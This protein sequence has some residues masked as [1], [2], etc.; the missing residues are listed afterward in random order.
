MHKNDELER[1]A[2]ALYNSIPRVFRNA[3]MRD[4]LRRLADHLGWKKI[5]EVL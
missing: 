3:A 2:I 4:F 5:K 1:E